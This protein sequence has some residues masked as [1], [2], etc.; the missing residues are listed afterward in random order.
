MEGGRVGS[1]SRSFESRGRLFIPLFGFG[2]G[3]E[4]VKLFGR[5]VSVVDGS[6]CLS[7]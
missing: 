6:G 3:V 5:A 2:S 7:P 4:G 1:R